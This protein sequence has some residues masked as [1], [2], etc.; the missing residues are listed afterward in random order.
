MVATQRYD[1]VPTGIS[2]V[3]PGMSK[4]TY[5]Y[6]TVVQVFDINVLHYDIAQK[7]INVITGRLL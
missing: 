6:V 1:R 2:R 5:K 7:I 3:Q 4:I